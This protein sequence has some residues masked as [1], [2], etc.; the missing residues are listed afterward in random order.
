LGYVSTVFVRQH[1]HEIIFFSNLY[2]FIHGDLDFCVIEPTFNS[3]L[4]SMTL[5]EYTQ[6]Y[7]VERNWMVQMLVGK[8]AEL[9]NEH[10]LEEAKKILRNKIWLG[11]Q[12]RMYE[13]LIRL[14]II[15]GWNQNPNWSVCLKEVQEGK[16]IS[17]KNHGKPVLTRES[18]E[19]DILAQIDDLDL[20]LYHFAES[21]FDQQ[22]ELID[23][24]S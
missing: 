2:A 13:S 8:T 18:E 21:L 20:K 7:F 15:Y 6:S 24:A 12:D 4:T 19:W 22:G 10:D 3:E 5:L 14:G 17:N 23:S 16:W 11:M 1:H 9:L